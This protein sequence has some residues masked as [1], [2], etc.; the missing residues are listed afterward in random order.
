MRV[1]HTVLQINHYNLIS[2]LSRYNCFK[3]N[4]HKIYL[5]LSDIDSI[6]KIE[7]KA[8]NFKI[9]NTYMQF[10]ILQTYRNYYCF[11]HNQN[12]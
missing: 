5:R 7:L 2:I 4:L 3:K 1:T 11:P 10:R 6:Q 12:K 9:H 8:I